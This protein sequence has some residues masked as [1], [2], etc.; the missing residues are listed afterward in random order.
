MLTMDDIDFIIS[1]VSDTLEDIVQCNEDKQET[2]Y[3][4]IEVELKRVQ[5]SLYSSRA[6]S[7]T[8]LSSE[9]IE[10]GDESS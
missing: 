9:G 1:T 5:Q 7:I 4:R 6:M 2:M 8:P 3:E 10:L